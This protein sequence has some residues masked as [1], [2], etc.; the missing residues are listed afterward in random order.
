MKTFL[1]PLSAIFFLLLSFNAV[2]QQPFSVLVNWQHKEVVINKVSLN[3][4]SSLTD[5]RKALGK[6]SRVLSAEGDPTR[7]FIYDSLGISFIIDTARG[8]LQRLTIHPNKGRVEYETSPKTIFTGNLFI[9]DKLV[10]ANEAISSIIAGT[11][12]PFKQVEESFPWYTAAN[13]EFSMMI[14]YQ[15][16]NRKMFSVLYVSFVREKEVEADTE[17]P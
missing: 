9:G 16:W 7:L 14:T 11:G 6:E 17:G 12:L 2:A 5:I 3:K 4:N 10:A 8:E 13:E 1:F 15:P